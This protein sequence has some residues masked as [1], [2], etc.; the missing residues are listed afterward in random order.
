MMDV[1]REVSRQVQS[2]V[3]LPCLS[4]ALTGILHKWLDTY[5]GLQP[6]SVCAKQV[7]IMKQ[8]DHPNIVKLVEVIDDPESDHFHMG[9]KLC[10][11]VFF[12][13]KAVLIVWTF[14]M[15]LFC[16]S[17]ISWLPSYSLLE[18]SSSNWQSFPV[19]QSESWVHA[20][21]ISRNTITCLLVLFFLD[22]MIWRYGVCRRNAPPMECFPF[23]IW[24]LY[25]GLVLQCWNMWME[26]GYLR[27]QA[28][29]DG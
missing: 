14:K 19:A 26:D 21:M 8:L 6:I 18:S 17:Q 15:A 25:I 24:R 1:L 7:A 4:R 29:Q 23:V 5:L 12:L 9:M 22:Y 16:W 13:S 20:K 3:Y 27:A 2:I 28:H 11:Y 10:F